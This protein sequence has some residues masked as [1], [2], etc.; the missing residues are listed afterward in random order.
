L[1]EH[2]VAASRWLRDLLLQHGSDASVIP[3]GFNSLQFYPQP[4]ERR[5]NIRVIARAH[6]EKPRHGFED[7]VAALRLVHGQRS[8]VEFLLYGASQLSKHGDLGFPYTDLGVVKDPSELCQTYNHSD[9]FLDANHFQGFGLPAL[10]AMSCQVA[11]VLTNF[12]GVQEYAVDGVNA[13]LVPPHNPRAC[14][15]AVLR[16]VS[17]RGL[18]QRLAIEGRKTAERMTPRGEAAAWLEFLASICP[19]FR[20]T[21]ADRLVSGIA[22]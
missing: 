1:L 17:D 22:A 21:H 20:Q 13:L 4:S 19:A 6:P 12:G 5:A 8:D 2:R 10:E 18:R 16:L 9:V 7:T 14:S 3:S 11:C 15:E